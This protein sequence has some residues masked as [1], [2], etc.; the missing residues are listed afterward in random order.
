MNAPSRNIP[1]TQKEQELVFGSFSARCGAVIVDGVF[2]SPW[3]YMLYFYNL[4]H[5]L[6][7]P[8]FLIGLLLGPTFKFYC[9]YKY[10]HTIGKW[11]FN[12]NCMSV[13]FSPLSLTQALIRNIFYIAPL[14]ITIPYY[15]RAFYSENF[16][17][18]DTI[19]KHGVPFVFSGIVVTLQILDVATIFSDPQK[20]A[21]HDKLA[22][23]LVVVLGK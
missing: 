9:E 15:Y 4:G 13:N 2:L 22:G 3:V 20:R 17:G 7:F 23:T 19:V 21:I 5:W 14:L 6:S 18:L 8:L 12:L 16:N 11:L 10:G 1:N